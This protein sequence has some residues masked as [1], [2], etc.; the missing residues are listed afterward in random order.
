MEELFPRGIRR[1]F[2]VG[3]R[4]INP[5]RKLSLLE[6]ARYTLQGGERFDSSENIAKALNPPLV[7]QAWIY[8][9]H[10]YV[11][12]PSLLYYNYDIII[13]IITSILIPNTNA[14]TVL[15][16]QYREAYIAKAYR[17][18]S[19]LL[20]S[21]INI[22]MSIIEPNVLLSIIEC[23]ERSYIVNTVIIKKV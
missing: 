4:K 10:I 18:P 23:D 20:Y 17:F 2:M 11:H 19:S 16:T 6:R 13:I 9:N 1:W 5:N 3:S 15:Y 21:I 22:V 14:L 12:V 7:R 8:I